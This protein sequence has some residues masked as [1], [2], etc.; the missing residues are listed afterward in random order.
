MS[1]TPKALDL[2]FPCAK[3]NLDNLDEQWKRHCP[4]SPNLTSGQHAFLLLLAGCASD[5]VGQDII[6]V[7]DQSDDYFRKLLQLVDAFFKKTQIT[8]LANKKCFREFFKYFLSLE[9]NLS[10]KEKYVNYFDNPLNFDAV[11]L[12]Q[13]SLKG[14]Y[15][16]LGWL[17]NVLS[18]IPVVGVLLSIY[19]PS[20]TFIC[21]AVSLVALIS[22]GV[23]SK[24]FVFKFE[25]CVSDAACSRQFRLWN[26]RRSFS[27][28]L[29]TADQSPRVT[30]QL[31]L[32]NDDQ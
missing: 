15:Q 8:I 16:D 9:N 23:L 13:E 31:K 29:N 10:N 1:Q 30:P 6:A 7:A 11:N 5:W 24:Y 28:Y 18:F 20:L 2:E 12:Q 14:R 19:Q 3:S 25:T 4:D 22:K 21:S 32:A 26:V 27:V 17:F